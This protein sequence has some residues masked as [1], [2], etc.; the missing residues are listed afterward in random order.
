MSLTGQ[1]LYIIIHP[2]GNL[3]MRNLKIGKIGCWRPERAPA[4]GQTTADVEIDIQPA[5]SVFKSGD[6]SSGAERQPESSI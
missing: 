6:A 5:E 2:K 4:A 3:S 1:Y